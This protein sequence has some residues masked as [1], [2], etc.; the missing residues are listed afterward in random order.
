MIK[1]GSSSFRPSNGQGQGINP[2]KRQNILSPLESRSPQGLVW[3][4]QIVNVQKDGSTPTPPFDPMSI[5]GLQIWLDADDEST[6]NT[7]TSGSEVIVSGWTSK[8]NWTGTLSAETETRAPR[9]ITD[10]GEGSSKAVFLYSGASSANNSGLLFRDPTNFFPITSGLTIFF[11]AKTDQVRTL[12]QGW[13][14]SSSFN[15]G[16]FTG[17]TNTTFG[18]SS[19]STSNNQ[20]I[21]IS[22][23][24]G[25][26]TGYQ[27]QIN[28]GFTNF[29]YRNITPYYLTAWGTD[30]PM[31]DPNGF[32]YNIIGQ[33][34]YTFSP[35]RI[36]SPFTNILPRDINQ[37]LINATWGASPTYNSTFASPQELYEIL[38]Y[39][40]E[41]DESEFNQVRN[42]LLNKWDNTI[43]V[44]TGYTE[45]TITDYKADLTGNTISSGNYWTLQE[46][47]PTTTW[48]AFLGDLKNSKSYFVN[49]NDTM[50]FNVQ[51]PGTAGYFVNFDIL[52]NGVSVEKLYNVQ[53]FVQ[54]PYI[55]TIPK[56]ITISGVSQYN[57]FDTT[58]YINYTGT[59]A[60]SQFFVYDR[61]YG[62][63]N[64]ISLTGIQV[65][66][67]AFTWTY[68]YGW[69]PFDIIYSD[70]ANGASFNISYL[71]DCIQGDVR[72]AIDTGSGSSFTLTPPLNPAYCVEVTVQSNP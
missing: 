37:V 61:Y 27:Q 54:S 32:G 49:E 3:G 31:S 40:R 17:S 21:V 41:L 60:S 64:I 12:E 11:F 66:N 7:Y 48:T 4:S 1:W 38:V 6:L 30:A 50:R 65:L 69:T 23:Q 28:N 67:T 72:I 24:T 70:T 71:N 20:T 34:Y 53:E 39:N 33:Q 15:L 16:M 9:F 10:G 46:N 68:N 58:I 19:I 26:T 42:Y 25:A 63:G 55:S 52:G 56:P 59:S 51:T 45:V 18:Q 35:Q 62:T 14:T 5:E 13:T 8:G 47:T 44:P 2:P 57:R 29:R 36:A 22:N 43:D